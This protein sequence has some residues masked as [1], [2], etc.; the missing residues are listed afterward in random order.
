MEA[1]HSS[2]VSR[3]LLIPIE[4]HAFHY[5]VANFADWPKDLRDIGHEYGTYA[6]CHW[7]HA[8]PD[9]S[10]HL[11]LSAFSLAVFGQGKSVKEAVKKADQFYVRSII[12]IRKEIKHLSNETIDQALAATTLM[13]GYEVA[14]G[15]LS[16]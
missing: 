11:A 5:W 8:Q 16:R 12:K 6:L 13:S 7:N 14:V 10:L 1:I 15:S 9:S 4:V 2:S 3:S